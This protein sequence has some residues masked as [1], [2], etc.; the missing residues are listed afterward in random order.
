MRSLILL[1]VATLAVG[2][3]VEAASLGGQAVGYCDAGTYVITVF[4]PYDPASSGPI[5]GLV[6]MKGAIGEC[7]SPV[8]VPE[9]PIPLEVI[10]DAGFFGYKYRVRILDS[11]NE[12]GAL[13][14]YTAYVVFP[15]GDTVPLRDLGYGYPPYAIVSCRDL[16]FLRGLLQV[17]IS[18]STTGTPQF[19]IEPCAN[20]CWTELVD[21]TDL[22]IE[23]LETSLDVPWNHLLGSVVDV[24]GGIAQSRISQTPSHTIDRLE[25]VDGADCGAVPVTTVRWG[26]IKSKYRWP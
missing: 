19:S 11:D 2:D 14:R 7:S 26:E 8:Q 10:D 13:F 5:A 20:G 22:S 15:N 21:G 23:V 4:G 12:N 16:P 1:V 18:E 17:D 25:L 24:Y 3:A 6:F 9:V